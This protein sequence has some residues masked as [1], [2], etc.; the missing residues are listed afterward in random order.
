MAGAKGAVGVPSALAMAKAR[1]L[2]AKGSDRDTHSEWDRALLT[3]VG[4][5]P[6][7]LSEIPAL[8]E[9]LAFVVEGY[10]VKPRPEGFDAYSTADAHLGKRIAEQYLRGRF[11]W[12]QGLGWL[13]WDGRRWEPVPEVAAREAVR[14][15]LIAAHGVDSKAASAQRE[16]RVEDIKKEHASKSEEI[17]KATEAADKEYAARLHSISSYFNIGKMK[18]TQTVAQGVLLEAGS[19]FDQHAYL[20]NV[21]NGVVD[22][23]TGVLSGHKP[24]WR[25]TK[26]TE[27]NYTPGAR[28][29]DWDT[30][31]TA[32]APEVMEWMQYRFGQAATGRTPSDD[33]VPIVQG[34]GANGKTTIFTGIRKALG[35]FA[36]TVPDKALLASPGDHPTEMMTFRG[37][38]LA[39]IEETPEARH[40]DSKRLKTLA[41]TEQ[42]TARLIAQNN[43]SWEPTHSLFV[44]SNFKPRVDES[45][46]GTWRR[47]A[48][49]VF[50][51][52]YG[53]NRPNDPPKDA[54]LRP[55]VR[56][57]LDGQHEAVLAWLIE[58]SKKWAAAGEI[59]PPAPSSVVADTKEWRQGS[60]LLTRFLDE[61][62]EQDPSR[63]VLSRE[64]YDVFADW[65]KDHGYRVWGDQ[66][67]WE[68]FKSHEWMDSGAV[69]KTIGT[70]RLEGRVFSSKHGSQVPKGPA[71]YLFGLAFQEDAA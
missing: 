22:L 25:F 2:E 1:F 31:L 26:I 61:V 37:A 46:H 50:P 21:G 63:A 32:L 34:G 23:R 14:V 12:A 27:V 35:D 20:L 7:D 69:E 51:Y 65:S 28:H 67:M 57:G 36:V 53:G 9:S 19:E 38:R 62:A 24:E 70:R 68:R 18:A 71:R 33:V 40:L 56:D 5:I 45:D 43:V 48:L 30:A 64:F 11:C 47:L 66:L 39:L 60:D 55:R 16:R 15:A 13:R 59:L 41:G 52:R 49:V 54:T 42:I 8:A 17:H 6:D 58:G 3:A 29:T 4:K 10:T 44:T